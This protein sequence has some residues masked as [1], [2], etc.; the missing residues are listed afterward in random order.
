MIGVHFVHVD[1]IPLLK[2]LY[3]YSNVKSEN[4]KKVGIVKPVY[5]RQPDMVDTFFRSQW[6]PLY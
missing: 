2:N 3:V 1:V 6:C 5:N 4:I